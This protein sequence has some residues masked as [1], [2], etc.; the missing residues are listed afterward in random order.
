MK[1]TISKESETLI[2]VIFALN[3]C[4]ILAV[5]LINGS[6]IY[7]SEFSLLSST[8]ITKKFLFPDSTLITCVYVFYF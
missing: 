5:I 1:F 4:P 7:N 2:L 8:H 3:E 6:K